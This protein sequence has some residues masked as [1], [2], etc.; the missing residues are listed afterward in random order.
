MSDSSGVREITSTEDVIDVSPD[1]VETIDTKVP[2]PSRH[3]PPPP[4]V[5]DASHRGRPIHVDVDSEPRVARELM[6]R[7]ILTIG[8][9]DPLAPLETQMEA[10]RFRHLPVVEGD[11]LVGLISHSDLLH[12]FSSKLSK[13]APEENAIIRSLPASRI[14]RTDV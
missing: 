7:E 8:P 13:S 6:T 12:A 1:S 14:M 5:R 11:V 9:E 2:A 10:F 4:R 3:P